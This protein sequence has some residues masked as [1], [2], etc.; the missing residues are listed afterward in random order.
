MKTK[1]MNEDDVKR[2]ISM[3]LLD[4]SVRVKN[5]PWIDGDHLSITIRNAAIDAKRPD[6]DTEPPATQ[7]S[8]EAPAG[9]DNTPPLVERRKTPEPKGYK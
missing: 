3:V 1:C 4:L 7:A 8:S 5:N 6:S 9:V 2:I